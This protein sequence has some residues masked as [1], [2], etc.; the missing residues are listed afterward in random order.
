MIEEHE[1]KQGEYGKMFHL[2]TASIRA[3]IVVP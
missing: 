3:W 1:T 2:S